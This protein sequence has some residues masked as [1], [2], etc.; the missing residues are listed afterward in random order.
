MMYSDDELKELLRKT[1]NLCGGGSLIALVYCCGITVEVDGK[2]KPRPCPI[3]DY[4]L[5]LLGIS[6]E[7]FRE[8]KEKHRL[9]DPNVC[10]KNLAYCCSLLKKCPVRDK[11]RERLGMDDEKYIEYK[12]RI[13][14]DLIPP[15]KL[16]YAVNTRVIKRLA[17][18]I[19]DIS[20]PT[21]EE[22]TVWKAEGMGNPDLRIISI[23]RIV[24][25]ELTKIKKEGE[26][27]SKS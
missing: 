26:E 4:A 11:A 20:D 9:Y 21:K 23:T 10:Y 1:P 7:R 24:S 2:E 27:K 6:K 22:W 17:M 8:V 3:R 14:K 25:K 15:D 19:F 12:L 5:K 16:E 18:I 13:L